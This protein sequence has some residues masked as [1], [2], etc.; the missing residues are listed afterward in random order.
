MKSAD[1][2]SGLLR[3]RPTA[4]SADRKRGNHRRSRSA[5]ARSTPRGYRHR[6]GRPYVEVTKTGL[7]RVNTNTLSSVFHNWAYAGWLVSKAGNIP[8]KTIR[9]E[10]EPIITTEELERGL[11]ILHL[12]Y[13]HRVARRK[14]DYLLKGFIFYDYD[15]GRRLVKLT[16]STSNAGRPG[17]GTAYYCVPRSGVNFLCNGIDDQIVGEL[18]HIQVDPDR[19][20]DIRAQYTHD[21]AKVLG[22]LGPDERQRLEA[23]L[24]AIDEEENRSVR[25]YAAG[26]ITEAVWD[27][28]WHEWQD[29][30]NTLRVSL[31]ALQHETET[32]IDN[33]DT[34]L[35]IIAQ[36]GTVYNA[37]TRSDQKELL[38]QMVERV[39]VNPVGKIKLE[40]RAPFAY[41][42]DLSHLVCDGGKDRGTP[43]KRKPA[44]QWLPV[45]ERPNVRTGSCTA[46]RTGFEPAIERYHPITA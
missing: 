17:G 31:D 8:P 33:L 39:V 42:N 27:S 18:L 4:S 6:S 23:A 20:P 36:V 15:D 3:F 37:L 40:L 16:G 5:A 10:W 11:A 9:G 24:K 45:H 12:R 46:G 34:A 19:I 44:A 35:A 38:R 43:G 32:H 30:R 25:L 1:H 13:Q 21:L 7:R 26:K 2:R 14:H 28:I 22:H 29:R 41:L